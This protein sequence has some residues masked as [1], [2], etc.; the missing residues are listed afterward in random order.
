MAWSFRVSGMWTGEEMKLHKGSLPVGFTE[1]P[2]IIQNCD[3]VIKFVEENGFFPS[4][5]FKDGK[6]VVTENRQ[7]QSCYVPMYDFGNPEPIFQMNKAV[8]EKIG[9]YSTQWQFDL[10]GI[11]DPSIQKYK[12]EGDHY[13][14]HHDDGPGMHRVVS[15]LVYLNTVHE[16]GETYFPEFDLKIKPEVGKLVI[17]PSNYIYR[18]AALS[19]ESGVKYAAAYW[20]Y[21]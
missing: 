15:A 5:V 19:P 13:D 10:R 16:G 7:S 1:Y 21:L 9:E 6:N 3:K 17:F 2:R 20:A 12:P 18:H 8:W 11:E 4:Y 14:F